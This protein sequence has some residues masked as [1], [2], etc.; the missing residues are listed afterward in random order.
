M[1]DD[2]DDEYYDAKTVEL[3]TPPV[4]DDDRSVWEEEVLQLVSEFED[5]LWV[6]YWMWFFHNPTVVWAA[7]AA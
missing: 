5:E 7:A 2:S 6:W 1:S 4:S 3:N